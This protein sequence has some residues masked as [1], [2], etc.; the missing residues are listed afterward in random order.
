[1][2]LPST[3]I[4]SPDSSIRQPGLVSIGWEAITVAGRIESWPE[5]TRVI[6]D[7]ARWSRMSSP[8]KPADRTLE[9]PQLVR[10]GVAE[11]PDVGRRRQQHVQRVQRDVG[12]ELAG[13]V[14]DPRGDVAAVLLDPLGHQREV[15][16]RVG[17]ALDERCVIAEPLAQR[18][19]VADHA[20]V[21]EQPA[22]LL[23]RVRVLDRRLTRGGVADVREERARADLVGVGDERLAA[24]RGD[25]LA[26]DPRRAVGIERP[27]PD[28]IGLGLAQRHEARGRV[29]Q[30]ERRLHL[31]RPTAHP[32]QSTHGGDSMFAGG[33]PRS[34]FIDSLARGY[35][36]RTRR[37]PRP[38]PAGAEPRGPRPQP[39]H[40][41]PARP[42][43]RRR[44]GARGAVRDRRVS[45]D[46]RAAAA[47][48]VRQ[49]HA[50]PPRVHP[51]A[52]PVGRP[53]VSHARRSRLSGARLARADDARL[54]PRV[55]G[56]RVGGVARVRASDRALRDPVG[57]DRRR[58]RRRTSAA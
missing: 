7:A 13:R 41:R 18:G 33:R 15:Q 1:M 29:Q 50:A 44:H 26:I 4:S 52:V 25:G 30:P 20:V 51:R 21:R 34:R 47:R 10:V 16:L 6:P 40:A 57:D 5:N 9:D 46:A 19:Q 28:P 35:R 27:E 49:R 11:R 37:A 17:R 24:V 53:V 36:V 55:P 32:E 38:H 58:D 3:W 56:D 54:L 48:R 8:P 22:V 14:G 45:G 39:A 23:E 12:G 42:R 43:P 2:Q 31:V